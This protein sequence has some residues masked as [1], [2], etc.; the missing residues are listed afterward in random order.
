MLLRA[1]DHPPGPEARSARNGFF[2]GLAA[3]LVW[4]FFP[5][6][7]KGLAAVPPLE[8][9]SHRIVWS[10]LFLV[11]LVTFSGRWRELAG[12][13][14]VRATLATLCA[15]TLLIAVNWLVFVHAVAAGQVL[16]SSLGYFITPLVN[17]LLGFA[18]LGE[19]LRP[20]QLVSILLAAAG[21]MVLALRVG[22]VPWIALVLAG[23]FGLYGL[24]R[25]TVAVDSLLGLTIETCLAAPLAFLFL[26][27]Q[28]LGGKGAFLG[29]SLQ[30]DIMLPLA[31]V[32]TAVPLLLFA[33]AARRLRLTTIGF[34]QYLTPSIHFLLA[35]FL[36]GEDFTAPHQLAFACIWSGLFLYGWTTI[37]G[38]RRP[39]VEDGQP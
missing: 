8:V 18:V 35:V 6:Y 31:G 10:M 37:R 19:R 38:A 24:L 34:L 14:R 16:Q 12:A 29:V 11:V 25:K 4:G 21:V 28:T 26:L 3:Y 23:T 2:I 9:V 1:G 17:M 20:L 32:V 15:T 36:F 13:L 22:H 7:F 27:L 33:A 39:A 5:L 30:H